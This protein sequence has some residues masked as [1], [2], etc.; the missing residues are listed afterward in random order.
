VGL[1]SYHRHLN[2]YANFKEVELPLRKIQFLLQI[3]VDITKTV[4]LAKQL[5]TPFNQL[6]V[7]G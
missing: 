5:L 1:A 4:Q 2:F 6:L 7:L 3:L